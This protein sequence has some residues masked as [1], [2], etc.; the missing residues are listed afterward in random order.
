MALRDDR[1]VERAAAAVAAKRS[2]RFMN[3]LSGVQQDDSLC[4]AAA[5]VK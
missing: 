2:R 5:L 1:V 3:Q 4:V